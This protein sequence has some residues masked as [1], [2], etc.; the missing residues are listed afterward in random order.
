[1]TEDYESCIEDAMC[2]ICGGE[3]DGKI[4]DCDCTCHELV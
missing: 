2:N 4:E 3:L 1:M